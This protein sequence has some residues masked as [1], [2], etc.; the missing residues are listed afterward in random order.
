MDFYVRQMTVNRARRMYKVVVCLMG[1]LRPFNCPLTPGQHG[2]Q[3]VM[4]GIY[5]LC[6]YLLKEPGGGMNL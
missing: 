2:A 6:D 1:L 3:E 4:S 5:I